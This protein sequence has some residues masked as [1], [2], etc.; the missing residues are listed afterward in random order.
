MALSRRRLL[1][2]AAAVPVLLVAER[3]SSALRT[4]APA[5]RPATTG[6]SA[7]RCAQCGATDHGMLHPRCP[8]APRL[9]A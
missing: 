9:W 8:R 5:V 2:A 4:T 3:A 6:T 7:T 1:A